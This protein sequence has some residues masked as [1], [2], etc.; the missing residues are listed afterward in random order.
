MKEQVIEYLKDIVGDINYN[1]IDTYKFNIKYITYDKNKE[2]YEFTY[3]YTRHSFLP[4]YL[5]RG[6]NELIKKKIKDKLAQ[7]GMD[8]PYTSKLEWINEP[9]IKYRD[10]YNYF[11]VIEEY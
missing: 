7:Y 8:I 5:K 10:Q 1:A 4:D 2:L 3:Q 6:F 9:N 11:H